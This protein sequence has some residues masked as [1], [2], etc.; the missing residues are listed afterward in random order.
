MC[1]VESMKLMDLYIPYRRGKR[2][3]VSVYAGI[4]FRR[5]KSGRW[6]GFRF[7]FYL[8]RKDEEGDWVLTNWGFLT[9]PIRR[10]AN[11]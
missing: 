4:M 3:G 11:E 1:E 5:K 7:M 2:C 10:V 9:I 6:C 8:V